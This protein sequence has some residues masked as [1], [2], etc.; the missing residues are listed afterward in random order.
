MPAATAEKPQTET[1]FAPVEFWNAHYPNEEI[2]IPTSKDPAAAK[3]VRFFAGYFRATEPWQVEAIER[4]S[5]HA[6]RGNLGESV[7]CTTCGWT[8]KNSAAFQF[9]VQQHP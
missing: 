2:R 9:H 8:T 6:K 3:V 1:A 4:H 5:L 7:Q